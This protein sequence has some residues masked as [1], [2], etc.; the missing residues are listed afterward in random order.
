MHRN[1]KS[2]DVIEYST[3]AKKMTSSLKEMKTWSIEMENSIT[4]LVILTLKSKES[5]S[6]METK[7]HCQRLSQLM[8]HFLLILSNA[9]VHLTMLEHGREEA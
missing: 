6:R 1:I 2:E 9:T 8:G 5:M 4:H 3:G 7:C